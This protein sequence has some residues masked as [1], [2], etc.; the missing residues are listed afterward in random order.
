M[1]LKQ[2][3]DEE[4]FQLFLS[5]KESKGYKEIYKRYFSSLAK[6]ASWTTSDIEKGKDLA[7][8]VLV[9]LYE[10]PELFDS[11]KSLK[12]WLFTI[13]KNQIKNEW[14]NEGNR[15][16]ILDQLPKFD[17]NTP[18][19]TQEKEQTQMV[20]EAVSSLSENHKEAFLLKYSNNLTIKEIS[21]YLSITE[22][23]VKSRIF[24]AIKAIRNH[25]EN[26]KTTND[27]E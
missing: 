2:R 15:K 19:N 10:K 22:G 9:K 18:D 7:Q 1:N 20:S 4:L 14:R 16:R 8:K 23:T 17:F 13:L 6:H 24:Y 3:T 12:I 5:G 25:I 21:T 11:N 26:S 27:G